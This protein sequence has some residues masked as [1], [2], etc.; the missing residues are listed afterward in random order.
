MTDNV[1]VGWQINGDWI[2]K[3]WNDIAS[4]LGCTVLAWVPVKLAERTSQRRV[5]GRK[6]LAECAAEST[7]QRE[8]HL[9]CQVVFEDGLLGLMQSETLN[10]ARKPE[11]IP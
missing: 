8:N 6:A 4:Y 7:F 11:G 9:E 5:D 2:T 3:A 10:Y 1:V